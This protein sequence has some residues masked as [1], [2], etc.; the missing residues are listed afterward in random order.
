MTLP[1]RSTEPGA[2]KYAYC[3]YGRIRVKKEQDWYWDCE[4][5]T[6]YQ[7]RCLMQD[8]QN[9][10][11]YARMPVIDPYEGPWP[12]AD[13]WPPAVSTSSSSNSN[14]RIPVVDPYVPQPIS[15][16]D[17]DGTYRY[18]GKGGATRRTRADRVRAPS[19]SK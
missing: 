18:K 15:I 14:S 19:N 17:P 10:D 16:P 1:D 2:A 3:K 13:I 7:Q 9:R 5:I 8:V 6:S 4:P 12:P 11:Y